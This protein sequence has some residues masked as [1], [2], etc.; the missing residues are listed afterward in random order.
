MPAIAKKVLVALSGGVDSSVCVHLLKEQGYIVE[1][2]VLNMSEFHS[3]TVNAAKEAAKAMDIPLHVVDMTKQFEENVVTYFINE[4]RNGRTPNPCIVCNPTVKFNMLITVADQQGCD[5]VATGHYARLEHS[6]SGT[7]LLRGES[8]ARDQSYMLHRLTQRELTRLIFPLAYMHKDE[9]RRIASE[10][11]LSCATKPDSQE[12]CFIPDND[13]RGFIERRVG[14]AQVGNFIAP[15]GTVCG[16]HKGILHYT[17]GQRKGLGIALGR[18]VFVSGI[19][20]I[21]NKIFLAEQGTDVKDTAVI[22]NINVIS[23]GDFLTE[24]DAEVK[25]RSAAIPVPA[26]IVPI[27]H[28]KAKVLFSKPMRAVAA[29][30]SI[31]IYEGDYVVGGGFIE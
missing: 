10:L 23:G 27:G 6:K 3:D 18:P 14:K 22:T 26:Q 12:N 9:V 29:G 31:V 4:Y 8:I 20:P 15:D 17:V 24:F 2:V 25:I 5:F 16:E 13:Y 30:Q 28:N 19:D 11:S 1:A 21:Q 7:K